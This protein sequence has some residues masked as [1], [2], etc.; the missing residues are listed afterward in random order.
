SAVAWHGHGNEHQYTVPAIVLSTPLV[1]WAIGC[2]PL[3]GFAAY[4]FVRLTTRA[5]ADAPKDWRLPVLAPVNFAVI[6]VL[7]MR[8][9]Q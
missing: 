7:A 1:A 6:G 2:G 8:F 3:F 9:P 4:G 5:R